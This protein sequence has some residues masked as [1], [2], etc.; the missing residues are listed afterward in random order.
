MGL[1]KL[2]E[3]QKGGINALPAHFPVQRALFGPEENLHHAAPA[4]TTHASPA[5]AAHAY[6]SN[7][8]F[9]VSASSAHATHDDAGSQR[10]AVVFETLVALYYQL[11]PHLLPFFVQVVTRLYERIFTNSPQHPHNN[12]HS[13]S[14]ASV[15]KP[16]DFYTRA[17]LALPP[18]PEG[19]VYDDHL[20]CRFEVSFFSS[21]SP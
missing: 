2:E 6:A 16:P 1:S 20:T 15:P 13:W 8:A 14:E 9:G 5:H 11:K 10:K 17:L 19:E 12:R 7:S 18:L 4:I 3:I 21:P